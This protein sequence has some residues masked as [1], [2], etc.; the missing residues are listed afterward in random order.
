MNSE[1]GDCY[2][3]TSFCWAHNPENIFSNVTLTVHKGIIN[4][5]VLMHSCKVISKENKIAKKKKKK[6]KKK[7]RIHD[8]FP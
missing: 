2:A 4:G 6:K 3:D 1:D 8:L 7:K 5:K